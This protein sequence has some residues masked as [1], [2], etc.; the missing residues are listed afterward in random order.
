MSRPQLLIFRALSGHASARLQFDDGRRVH[1]HSA[2]SPEREADYLEPVN[3]WGEVVVLL[4]TGLGYH[5]RDLVEKLRTVRAVVLVDQHEACLEACERVI[6]PHLPIHR[7]DA[8]EAP[9]MDAVVRELGH[10]RIQVIRH[11]AS[12]D[13]NQVFYDAVEDRLLARQRQRRPDHAGSS[14]MVLT[15]KFF[16]QEELCVATERLSLGCIR[17][18]Y[19]GRSM[20]G[21]RQ[22]IEE[23]MVTDQPAALITVGFKGCDPDGEIL[24]LA[25]KYSVPVLVWF[26]D[27]PR[28]NCLAFRDSIHSG[29]FAFCWER[30]YLQEL[31]NMG[32]GGVEYLPLAA[33]MS[34]FANTESVPQD[35][36]LSFVGS[37]MSESF[38]NGIRQQFMWDDSLRIRVTER[39]EQLRW[40]KRIFSA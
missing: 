34:V 23:R 11:P 21:L 22:E 20:T 16:F 3:I 24:A 31:S 37:A 39:A 18:D 38:L 28:P 32:F 35:I 5:L 2:V 30:A 29:M 17:V 40:G 33:C 19:E 10:A 15:G 13:S 4:G 12:Y 1:L 7:V 6:G 27:D 14:I 26:V 9:S 8:L 36:S 25:R